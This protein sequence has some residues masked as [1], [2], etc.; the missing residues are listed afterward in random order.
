MDVLSLSLV[1]TVLPACGKL[2]TERYIERS[3]SAGKVGDDLVPAQ[4]VEI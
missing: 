3:V 1:F 4:H 2:Q